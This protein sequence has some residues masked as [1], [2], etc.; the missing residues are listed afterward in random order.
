MR[1]LSSQ[2]PIP[3][4]R[5][6]YTKA[7]NRL[8]ATMVVDHL[9]VIDHTLYWAPVRSVAEGRYLTALLNAP[10]LNAL[11]ELYMSRGDF[12][13]RHVDKY[14]W[15]VPIPEFNRVDPRHEAVVDLARRSEQVASAVNVGGLGFQRA[16][17]VIRSALVD[18]G[19]A[20]ELD[21]A[22]EALIAVS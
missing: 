17:G 8:A 16:R 21:R 19:L 2:F 3:Q 10:D 6:V 14:V 5:V 13:P 12:G 18:C 20:D 22:L 1:Q 11:V 9:G 4:R 15:L 7:G